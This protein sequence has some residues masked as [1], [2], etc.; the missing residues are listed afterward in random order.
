[1]MPVEVVLEREGRLPEP[2]EVAAYYVAAEALANIAKHA[3]ASHARVD[4]ELRDGVVRMRISDDGV[5]GA[6][7]SAG[8]GLTG[9][10]DRV[11]AL[12]GSL[13]VRSP[14]GQGTSLDMTLP[15][16]TTPDRTEA[17]G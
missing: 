7:P 3:E 11:E 17:S 14:R 13:A 10:R 6:S 1:M 4:V 16:A 9:L 15:L 2:V 5:G 8:S 12:G